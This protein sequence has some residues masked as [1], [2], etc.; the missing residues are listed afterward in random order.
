M[1]GRFHEPIQRSDSGCRGLE[2]KIGICAVEKRSCMQ[3]KRDLIVVEREFDCVFR[4][5]RPFSRAP[6]GC[7]SSGLSLSDVSAE[8]RGVGDADTGR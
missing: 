2:P 7:F 1:S 6:G 4:P 3:A 8:D 5:G